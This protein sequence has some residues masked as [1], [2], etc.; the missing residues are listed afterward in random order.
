MALLDLII[1]GGTISTASETFK[2]DIGIKDEKIEIIANK[3]TDA[4]EIIDASGKLVTPPF[5]DSHFHLRNLGKRLDMVQL[6][7]IDSLEKIQKLVM[8]FWSQLIMQIIPI[9]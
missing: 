8:K 3:L 7:G 6:K 9:L 1:A 5:I 4:N 2:A